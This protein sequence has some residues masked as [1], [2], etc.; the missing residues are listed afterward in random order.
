GFNVFYD[1][2]RF[3]GIPVGAG[4]FDPARRR[5]YR[6]CLTAR[7]ALRVRQLI[8]YY[9]RLPRDFWGKFWAEPV[10]K[11]PLRLAAKLGRH[12]ANMVQR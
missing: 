2:R 12:L 8:D 6:P 4:V 7:T 11:L 5:A 1:G 3:H 10:Y 9:Q